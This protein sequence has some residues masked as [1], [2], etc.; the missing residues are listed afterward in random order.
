MFG[1]RRP[2]YRQRSQTLGPLGGDLVV[3][4]QIVTAAARPSI[5]PAAGVA[6]VGVAVQGKV[7]KSASKHCN[8][9]RGYLCAM[10]V[11]S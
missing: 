3:L 4:I 8:T 6:A 5:L 10:F 2:I 1:I 7:N 11:V 9:V